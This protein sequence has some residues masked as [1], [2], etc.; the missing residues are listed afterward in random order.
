[1]SHRSVASEEVTIEPAY[2]FSVVLTGAGVGASDA[3]VY[4]GSN[5]S[6]EPMLDLRAVVDMSVQLHFDPPLVFNR[7]IYVEK[8]SNVTSIVFQF[9]TIA[10]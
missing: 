4:D 6:G 1:M 10:D 2:L 9:F 8:G 3:A 5:T 7:G